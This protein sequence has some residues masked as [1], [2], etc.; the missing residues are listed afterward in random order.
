MTL[1]LLELRMEI[2]ELEIEELHLPCVVGVELVEHVVDGIVVDGIHFCDA[3]PSDGMAVHVVFIER[4]PK[5]DA[6]VG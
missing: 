4:L 6:P 5:S 3:E 2:D 1:L